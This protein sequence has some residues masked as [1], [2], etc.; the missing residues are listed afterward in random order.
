MIILKIYTNTFTGLKTP[1]N[2][3]RKSNEAGKFLNGT[4]YKKSS[5]YL[6]V[7]GTGGGV[8]RTNR[9]LRTNPKYE[10]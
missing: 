3:V 10:N 5:V 9:I 6:S 7:L 4:K 2:R 1:K 8:L